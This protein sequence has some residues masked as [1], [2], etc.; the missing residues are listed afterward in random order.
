MTSQISIRRANPASFGRAS[1][2]CGLF[3]SLALAAGCSSRP[4]APPVAAEPLQPI[5]IVLGSNL[6]HLPILV[7]AEKGFFKAHGLDLKLKVVN[8][9]SEMV[10]AMQK[11]EVELG[12]MSVT[13]FIKAKHEGDALQVVGLIMNDATRSNADEPLAIISKNGSGIRAGQ[14]GDLKGRKVAVMLGQTPHEYLKIA[15]ARAGLAEDDIVIVNMP[16]SPVIADA[17]RDG[18]VD[19]VASLEP[20]NSLVM[21][22]VPGAYEVKRGGG[23]LSYLMITTAY[24]PTIQNQADVIDRFAAGLAA[25]SQYTRQHREEAVQIFAR[26]VPG[27]DTRALTQGIRHVSYDPR[28][29]AA[30]DR[31]F[32]AAQVDVLSQASLRGKTPI[33]LDA[34]LYRNA[35]QKAQRDFPQYFSDLPRLP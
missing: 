15:A 21:Q 24:L 20:L 14:I 29:S 31:A 8:N 2:L 33:P 25:A 32:D 23:Y 30:T 18:T 1:A 34:L 22:S 9:G 16:Q 26:A 12:D 17:L 35:I 5:S 4:E 3:V 27:Q 6:G 19:A 13:T 28:M 10:S 7:G 11:R